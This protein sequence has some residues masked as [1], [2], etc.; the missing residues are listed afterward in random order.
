MPG[1]R[2]RQ[3]GIVVLYSDVSSR[4]D[5]EDAGA[6]GIEEIRSRMQDREGDIEGYLDAARKNGGIKVR[7]QVPPDIVT[8]WATEPQD[9]RPAARVREALVRAC[10]RR[11]VLPVRRAGTVGRAGLDARGGCRRRPRSMSPQ[12]RACDLGR[13]LGR[14]REQAVAA[15]LR[16][17]PSRA[18]ST[19]CW[20]IVIPCTAHT[21]RP[22]R[23]AARHER[24]ARPAVREG[25]ARKTHGQRV[26]EPRRLLRLAGRA[27]PRFP[28]SPAGRSMPP[29]RRI[30]LRDDCDG[31]RVQ[32]DARAQGAAVPDLERA[33]LHVRARSGCQA[34]TAPCSTRV[35]SRSTTVRCASGSTTSS[36]DGPR[37][38][39]PA[40]L[41]FAA[42]P[43]ARD[44]LEPQGGAVGAG[45]TSWR[46]SRPRP[47]RRRPAISSSCTAPPIARACGSSSMSAPGV[48]GRT[49]TALRRPGHCARARAAVTRKRQGR[50]AA[51]RCSRPRRF[52]RQVV[53]AGLRLTGR[54]AARL[55][56]SK[57]SSRCVPGREISL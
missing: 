34:S 7:I 10:R 29:S 41:Q 35:T 21:A 22:P 15:R 30:G 36:D 14:S 57:A 52:R 45:R 1:N 56:P 11:R 43:C 47:A 8:H 13:L 25:G 24:Q 28:D 44:D 33:A 31:P 4:Q 18:S 46:S 54:Q 17:T 12:E 38:R 40:R 23:K 2:P 20:S 51:E 39:R 27:R 37:V 32:G 9:S 42:S 48:P 50:Q 53:P 16:R 5:E 19:S 26:P 55:R 6:V 49:R 3:G